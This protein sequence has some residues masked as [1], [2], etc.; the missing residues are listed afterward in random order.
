MV[1]LFWHVTAD[2]SPEVQQLSTAVWFVWVVFISRLVKYIEHFSRF[3]S[4]VLIFIFLVPLFGYFH[5]LVIKVYAGITM[6]V[7]SLSQSRIAPRD[8][9]PVQ[10]LILA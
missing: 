5:S 1:Y 4:D 6:G 8:P 9:A 7:V 3:P 10:L 2:L